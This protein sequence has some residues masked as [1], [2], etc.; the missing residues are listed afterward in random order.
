MKS[1]KIL[2]KSQAGV[3]F[4]KN[5]TSIENYVSKNLDETLQNLYDFILLMKN[6]QLLMLLINIEI[7]IVLVMSN[8]VYYRLMRSTVFV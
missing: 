6:K 1:K 3:Y 7:N 4:G 5:L 8:F 2:N